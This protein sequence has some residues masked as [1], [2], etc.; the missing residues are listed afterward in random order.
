MS[1]PQILLLIACAIPC[2]SAQSDSPLAKRPM[3]VFYPTPL[4]TIARENTRRYPWA[5]RAR[6]RIVAAA[7]PWKRRSDAALW[8]L[9]FG[10]GIKRSW[11]VWSD[12]HCPSC[13][14][15]VTMYQWE[16]AALKKPWKVGCPHCREFFPKN[17][18]YRY[19]ESGRDAS[20][21]FDP[22]RADRALLVNAEHPDPK[23]P[24][25]RFG[26]DDGEGYVEGEKR[27]RFIGAYL[28]YGQWKQAV[29]GGIRSLAAA[30]VV[31]GERLYAHKAAVLLDRVADLYP[32]FDFGKQGV[33]YE[34]PPRAGY[35]STWHD[36]CEET[37][38]LALAYD[39]IREGI[40]G[41][42][43]HLALHQP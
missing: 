26:V 6:D 43:N 33:M 1:W 39:K 15:S 42:S 3:S 40:E 16:V 4:V 5:A 19:Y 37:R 25:H 35:V 10:P 41:E 30:Y 28:I 21:L 8:E 24:L 34:G 27:W 17:D 38:E 2:A 11:M 18:F 23:D 13:R 20:G 12:G 14:K 7:R 29:L 22:A 9:M 31:T 36:A 32:L